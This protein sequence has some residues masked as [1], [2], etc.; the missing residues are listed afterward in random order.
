M[1]GPKCYVCAGA[2][3][4]WCAACG[5]FICEQHSS[6]ETRERVDGVGVFCPK[7][8]IIKAMPSCAAGVA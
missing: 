3:A 7:C 4:A 6:E 8:S 2:P 5:K 1:N